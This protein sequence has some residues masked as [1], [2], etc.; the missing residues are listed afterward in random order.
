MAGHT[1]QCS[2]IPKKAD[3]L[4]NRGGW[5]KTCAERERTDQTSSE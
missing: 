2:F 3:L 5:R 1:T 4:K